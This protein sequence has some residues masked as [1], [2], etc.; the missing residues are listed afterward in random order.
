MERVPA[1]SVLNVRIAVWTLLISPVIRSPL[2]STM[3]SV[4]GLSAAGRP[5]HRN[6]K[7]PPTQG[8]RNRLGRL[9]LQAPTDP[10]QLAACIGENPSRAPRLEEAEPVAHG[11]L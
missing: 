4:F 10:S 7:I 2:V 1:A 11:Q 5:A 9:S 8:R 3:T 6:R